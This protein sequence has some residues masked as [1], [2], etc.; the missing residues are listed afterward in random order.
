MKYFVHKV[1]TEEMRE[2][3]KAKKSIEESIKII[4]PNQYI[5][6]LD[7]SGIAEPIIT[8]TVRVL[9]EILDLGFPKLLITNHKYKDYFNEQPVVECL[10]KKG[11]LDVM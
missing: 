8:S 7:F 5:L 3:I 1:R 11:K 6:E 2:M 9:N 10:M 4:D